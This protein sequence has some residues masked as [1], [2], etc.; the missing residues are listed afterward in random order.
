[1]PGTR[2]RTSRQLA[3]SLI[4][5]GLLW[6]GGGLAQEEPSD[7]ERFGTLG[8]M[9]IRDM[10]PFG[11]SRLDML[12]AH[13]VTATPGTWAFEANM[14][15]QNTWALSDNVR[16]FLAARGVERGAI[17]PDDVAAILALPGD[18]YLVDGELGLIDLTLHYRLSE[19]F[20]LYAT[21]PYFLFSSG[22]LD[23]TIE[24]FHHAIGISN[25]GRTYVPRNRFL[26]VV[27]LEGQPFLLEDAPENE[28][29]DP[30]FGL[31]YTLDPE[32]EKMNIVFEAATKVVLYDSPRLV[33]TGE[34]DYGLQVSFQR[35]FR[36]NALYLTA[37]GVFF[38]SPEPGLGKNQVLPTFIAGWETRVSRHVNFVLQAYWSRSNVQET[39]LDELSANKIQATMGLQWLYR[40]NVLRFGIT[41]NI[42][43]FDNTPDIGV[44]LSLARILFN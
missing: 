4:A 43:N 40:G 32:P 5:A 26:A 13:A 29:G 37:S 42:A 9:R 10:T 3:R 19:H 14:S 21:M 27:D 25:G 7:L 8:L 35:F 17:S 1:M 12:P 11:I 28:F 24:D 18:G 44:N 16:Q 6:A 30:V 41:E 36:R 34:N 2:C 15:Y 38:S 22:F 20:G 39:T 31:R 23:A 33:S